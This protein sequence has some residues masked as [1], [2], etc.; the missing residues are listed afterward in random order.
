M[1]KT[2]LDSFINYEKKTDFPY[3]RS[4]K[5]KRV[6]ILFELLGLDLKPLKAIHI[7]GTKGKGSTAELCACGLSDFRVGLYTSPHFYDFRE[8]IRINN[9]LIPKKQVAKITDQIR[10][11]LQNY[12]LPKELGEFS[13]FEIHTA[14]A[15]KYFLSKDL[16]YLVLETGLGGRLDATNLVKPLV[17]IITHIGYDHTQQLGNSLAKIAY[18]KAGI[19]K[20]GVPIVTCKQDPEALKV[21]K[22]KATKTK[23]R[24]FVLGRDFKASNIRIKKDHTLFDFKFKQHSL[25]NLKIRLKGKHQVDNAALALVASIVGTGHCPVPTIRRGL[26]GCQLPGRFEILSKKPLLVC[27]I[28]HNQSSFKVLAQ[29]LKTYFPGKKVI[30]IFACAKDKD[31]LAMLKALK[32]WQV[33]FT[34]FNSP[35]AQDPIYLK[36]IFRRGGSMTRPCIV[37]KTPKNALKTAKQMYNKD[38]LIL[39]AGSIHLAAEVKKYA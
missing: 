7:A 32:P 26:A 24:L 35:R 12:K 37:D 8:R 30:L 34:K 14:I 16:D 9:D 10:S 17:S 33:I 23:S 38:C 39:I 18:E 31:A 20:P 25:K 4:F 1:A 19:I 11:C 21:I 13:F 15:F 3:R 27:D 28:A 22:A 2:Y 29:S 5:L 6:R 36:N